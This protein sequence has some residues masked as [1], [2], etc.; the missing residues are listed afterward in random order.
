MIILTVGAL[1][2]IALALALGVATINVSTNFSGDF[3]AT[4]NRSV[5]GETVVKAN[6]TVAAAIAGTLT[7]RTNGTS[8]TLTLPTG[9]GFVT[10][11]RVDL[12]WTGGKCYRAL[13]GTVTAT[14]A[15]I[16]SVGGGDALPAADSV[17]NV[18]AVNQ[19]PFVVTGNNVQ[20][21]ALTTNVAGYIILVEDHGTT[22]QVRL[23]KYV[24]PG[25]AFLWDSGSDID[26]PL[27][28]LTITEAHFSQS[29][30][31]AVTNGNYA[32]AA[33]N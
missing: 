18:A 21:L 27:E 24:D 15:P 30:T 7:V 14:T 26:N 8:G 13:L 23:V 9:H 22:E 32:Y 20:A 6:P 4:S 16:A 5:T 28:N 33:V 2:V 17:I 3:N 31:T 1:I 10:G 29:G 25:S 19:A 12:Y 11:Q